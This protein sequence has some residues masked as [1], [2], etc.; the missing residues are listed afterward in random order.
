MIRKIFGADPLFLIIHGTVNVV[1]FVVIAYFREDS[2]LG[3][4]I[5]GVLITIIYNAGAAHIK[6]KGW[7][8]D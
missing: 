5:A 7:L 4:A 3:M 2:L 8:D 6:E 1:I